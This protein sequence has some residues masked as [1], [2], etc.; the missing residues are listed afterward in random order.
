MGVKYF[1]NQEEIAYLHFDYPGGITAHLHV[2]WLSPL[3]IRRMMIVGTKKMVVYDDVELSEKIKIYDK[4]VL[5]D[6]EQ[7]RIG[8]RS[9]DL[10]APNLDIKEALGVLASEFVLA[11][12]KKKDLVSSGEFGSEVVNILEKATVSARTGKK[13][14]LKNGNSKK[15]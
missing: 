2:S 6:K 3:K 7:V 14:L 10:L 4:G 13:I 5:I 8:Y 15:R 12:E 11:L 9:G 1:S